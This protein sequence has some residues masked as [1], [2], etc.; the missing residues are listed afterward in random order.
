M[1]NYT[2]EVTIMDAKDAVGAGNSFL[3]KD[4]R[5]VVVTIVAK[6]S[7]AL[8]VYAV[9]AISNEEPDWAGDQDSLSAPYEFIQMRDYQD[10]SA[11][12]GDDGITFATEDVR[13]LE[14]N[15]NGL[16]WLNFILAACDAGNVTIKAVGFNDC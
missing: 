15:T 6:D 1:R 2:E 4:F 11:V 7:P 8:Q 5:H 10:N 12:N 13:M 3:V 14:I 16:V 9:G